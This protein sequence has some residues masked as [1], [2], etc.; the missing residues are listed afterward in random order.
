MSCCSRQPS[1]RD[2]GYP[3]WDGKCIKKLFYIVEPDVGMP[4]AQAHK[5][6]KQLINGVVCIY[7]WFIYLVFV[8]C[9]PGVLPSFC[10]LD[11]FPVLILCYPR[12]T[13]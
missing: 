2:H 7:Y 10:D 5:Y 12:K 4:M 13:S 8:N 1:S 6:F 9:I 3:L 11:H